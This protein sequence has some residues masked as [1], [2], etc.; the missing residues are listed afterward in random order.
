M[1][2][3]AERDDRVGAYLNELERALR[4]LPA[5]QATELME[6]ITAHLDEA[7]PPGSAEETVAAALRRLGSPAKLAAE[8]KTTV[9]LDDGAPEV[10]RSRSPSWPLRHRY[11]RRGW[12]AI[13]ACLALVC[14]LTTL[15][16]LYIATPSLSVGGF[17]AWWSPQ[18]Q[19][20]AVS[21]S[22][23]GAA[24]TTVPARRAQWQGF[25]V[26]V[27]NSSSSAQTVLGMAPSSTNSPT[28]LVGMAG[29]TDV[30][31]GVSTYSNDTGASP[32]FQ[33]LH[34]TTGQT[35]EPGQY[36]FLRVMWM[37]DPCR[38]SSGAG[39]TGTDQLNLDVQVGW[40]SREEHLTLD[41]GW[42]LS[43]GSD[44]SS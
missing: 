27:E 24:A 14:V 21:S 42:Q 28:G 25:V 29:V 8:A 7:L 16:G 43:F 44:C 11:G 40:F 33:S 17:S 2:S 9:R 10:A 36:R 4:V 31:V 3:V 34:F 32:E 30:T 15:L 13:A 18:D 38:L 12:G 19:A 41:P 20:R 35:I 37:T 5:P 39:T 22:T 26:E 23:L 1:S 6:Q